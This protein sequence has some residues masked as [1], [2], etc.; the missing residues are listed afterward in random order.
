MKMMESFRFLPVEIKDHTLLVEGSYSDVLKDFLI[1]SQ[2][3]F[4]LCRK[5]LC[6]PISLLHDEVVVGIASRIKDA[7]NKRVQQ[8]IVSTYL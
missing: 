2:V 3:E 7:R 4:E 5:H 6:I 1:K 8:G